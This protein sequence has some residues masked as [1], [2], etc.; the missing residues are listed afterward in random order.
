M[1]LEVSDV[2]AGYTREVPILNG[3][4]LT[5]E[6]GRVTVI[7]GPNGAGKSTL[8][9]TIYGYLK[10]ERGTIKHDGQSIVGYSPKDMLR[11]GIAYLIQGHSI[12]PRMTVEENLE[13]GG[14]IMGSDS[15]RREALERIYE[16]YPRLKEKR[17][18]SAGILS[19]GEQRILEIARLTMTGPRTLLLDEPSVGLMPKLVNEVYE[20]ISRLKDEKYTIL[21]VDQNVK[22]SI[23]IADYV[24]ALALG[25]NRHEGT[26]E[27]FAE[28]L[29]EIVKE[30]I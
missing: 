4:D 13:L 18:L 9:K 23:S 2:V 25:E 29:D 21:I 30:W 3:L 11:K 10:P 28:R 12:F 15:E 20:E 19:G 5:A 14:W 1:S 16:R 7:I 27:E 24:Y 8:L 6:D 26:K 22:K 17:R